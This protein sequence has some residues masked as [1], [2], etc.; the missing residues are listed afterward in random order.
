VNTNLRI[1]ALNWRCQSH[2][3]AGGS[4]INIFEQARRWV[5]E[6]HEVTI[7]TADPGR[8]YAAR[9]EEQIDGITVR[10]MGG[11][12][13]IYLFAAV[14]LL[15]NA[16]R[17]DYIIDIANGIPFFTP[18]F[19]RKPTVLLTHHV[20]AEQWYSELPRP[21]ADLGWLLE[22]RVVPWLYRYH[23]VIAVS[24]TT[25]DGLIELGFNPAQIQ[26]VYNGIELSIPPPSDGQSDRYRIA[27]VGRIRRY[28]RLDLLVRAV[29]SLRNSHPD[30]HLDIAGDGEA[31]PELEALVKE[32]GMHE[33][34]TIHGFVDEAAKAQ[35]LSR[36]TVF[37]TPSMHEG[38]GISVIEANA[39]GCPAVAYNVPGLC[40]SIRHG[41]TGLLA[42]DDDAFRDSLAHII[43]SAELR[44]HLAAGARRWAA[45][46]NWDTSAA[47]TL[48]VFSVY[49]TLA[50]PAAATRWESWK[51]DAR[52]SHQ[53]TSP[54]FGSEE[55]VQEAAPEFAR[56]V[57]GFTEVNER[58]GQPG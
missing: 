2:P 57:A 47:A 36:A 1:L 5:Q 30:L 14:F 19:T 7:V 18:L 16:W 49:K 20:H 12:F 40:V 23:P 55:P 13:T 53:S 43:G 15:L 31:R 41:E 50:Q 51:T 34:V 28:K 45:Q 17:F 21:L 37:A 56:A 25:R 46:F 58:V 33:H 10:R 42:H 54:A 27:Y 39:Y 8:E 52:Q 35:I 32:L 22:Q 24:P 38:W 44:S 6:G 29:D 9:S 48:R 4:E 26:I 11:R 3:Q